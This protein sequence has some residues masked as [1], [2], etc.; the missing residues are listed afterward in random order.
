MSRRAGCRRRLGHHHFRAPAACHCWQGSEFTAFEAGR[1]QPKCSSAVAVGSGGG[2]VAR[3][4]A[5]ALLH[6]A[7][8]CSGAPLVR[9]GRC[10]ELGV[11]GCTPDSLLCIRRGWAEQPGASKGKGKKDGGHAGVAAERAPLRAL[12]ATGQRTGVPRGS[13]AELCAAGRGVAWLRALAHLRSGPLA[14]HH[15]QRCAADPTARRLPSVR[16]PFLPAVSALS[17]QARR[18]RCCGAPLAAS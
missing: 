7:G 17:P 1:E 13:R 8:C 16:L 5:A 14:G 10:R 15:R 11:A 2:V 4:A 9:A 6:A 12:G 3:L 18:R